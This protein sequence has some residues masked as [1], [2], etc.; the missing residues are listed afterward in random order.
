MS[1]QGYVD[2]FLEDSRMGKKD[3]LYYMFEIYT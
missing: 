1:R 2:V 3:T